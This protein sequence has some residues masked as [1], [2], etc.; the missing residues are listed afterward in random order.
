MKLPAY[1][2][3]SY[4]RRAITQTN[5]EERSV[6]SLRTAEGWKK[7]ER[8]QRKETFMAVCVQLCSSVSG[9]SV[10]LAASACTITPS[11]TGLPGRP[12]ATAHPLRPAAAA[13][14][15]ATLRLRLIRMTCHLISQRRYG[16]IHECW[17]QI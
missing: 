13:A 6:K 7:A 11:L 5:I 15:A 1:G 4:R 3:I 14:E 12:A 9:Q 16:L 10:L 17:A 8:T 2:D